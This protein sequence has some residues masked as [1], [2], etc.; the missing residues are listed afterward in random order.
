MKAGIKLSQEIIDQ[1]VSDFNAGMLIKDIAV[2]HDVHKESVTKYTKL[3]GLVRESKWSSDF[4]AQLKEEYLAGETL[5]SLAAKYKV[6]RVDL[7]RKL[8]NSGVKL[9][10]HATER[11]QTVK[12]NPFL[13]L[14]NP[15]VQYWLGWLASDGCITDRGAIILTICKDPEMLNKYIDFIGED[16]KVSSTEQ[17]N[18]P[19][20]KYYVEFYNRK[21]AEYLTGLGIT[22]RKSRT[23]EIKFDF[24]WNFV[25]GY[26]DGNGS[27]INYKLSSA[28]IWYT[29]SDK[30]AGQLESFFIKEGYQARHRIDTHQREN[31]FHIINIQKVSSSF[32]SKLYPSDCTYLARKKPLNIINTELKT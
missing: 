3:A 18:S 9:L 29:A 23:L 12:H 7:G 13:D 24:D 10:D 4:L 16:V 8:K 17:K 32:M 31:P 21:L 28:L 20:P 1:I 11:R 5:T 15:D 27:C 22:P 25:R 2:K 14:N 19:N 6:C 26:L 30:F